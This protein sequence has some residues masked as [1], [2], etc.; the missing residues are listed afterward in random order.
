M[1]VKEG[2]G[3]ITKRARSRQRKLANLLVVDGDNTSDVRKKKKEGREKEKRDVEKS[4][5]ARA[6]ARRYFKVSRLQKASSRITGYKRRR[7]RRLRGAEGVDF[8]A[9][10]LFR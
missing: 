1:S 10:R 2:L 7:R 6:R 9:S 3:K 4:T 8:A 5:R